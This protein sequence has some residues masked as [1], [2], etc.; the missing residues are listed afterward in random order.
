MYLVLTDVADVHCSSGWHHNFTICNT[1]INNTAWVKKT[2]HLTFDHNVGKYRPI[3]KI[4]SLADSHVSA[5]T[6]KWAVAG[7]HRLWWRVRRTARL[8][9]SLNWT[10]HWRVQTSPTTFEHHR[11]HSTAC[12]CDCCQL[13]S[14]AVR[15]VTDPAKIRI[16][17]MRISGAKSVQYR[18]R[19]VVQWKLIPAIIATAIQLSLD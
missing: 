8:E 18:C 3:F 19:F 1:T 14:T 6:H 9:W 11:C 15:D 4:L 2:M 12:D 10:S 17:R 13:R 7:S 16:R 5:H